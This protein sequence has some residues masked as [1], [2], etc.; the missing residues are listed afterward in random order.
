MVDQYESVVASNFA[1]QEPPDTTGPIAI[2]RDSI[3]AP[4]TIMPNITDLEHNETPAQGDGERAS[5][6]DSSDSMSDG[7]VEI[8][9]HIDEGSRT[10]HHTD[11]FNLSLQTEHPA[12]ES[13]PVHLGA[14]VQDI[15]PFGDSVEN[16]PQTSDLSATQALDLISDFPDGISSAASHDSNEAEESNLGMDVL[17]TP[18]AVSFN[19]DAALPMVLSASTT[20]LQDDEMTIDDEYVSA[21]PHFSN[22]T[23]EA[24]FRYIRDNSSLIV[25]SDLFTFAQDRRLA[26]IPMSTD[27]DTDASLRDLRDTEKFYVSDDE[28]SVGDTTEVE[29]GTR[30]IPETTDIYT[31]DPPLLGDGSYEHGM[32][33]SALALSTDYS[34][35]FDVVYAQHNNENEVDGNLNNQ[36]GLSMHTESMEIY[37]LSHS[38]AATAST[39]TETQGTASLRSSDDRSLQYLG[40]KA[41][42]LSFPELGS[43]FA[44]H[45]S[46]L[47]ETR[48]YEL[49][50]FAS[51]LGPGFIPGVSHSDISVNQ[52]IFSFLSGPRA[53]HAF[54]NT[55]THYRECILDFISRRVPRWKGLLTGS[56]SF[57]LDQTP[58]SQTYPAGESSLSPA[59]SISGI[60]ARSSSAR[61]RRPLLSE[62]QYHDLHELSQY[63]YF[64]I[65]PSLVLQAFKDED[66]LASSLLASPLAPSVG[67]FYVDANGNRYPAFERNLTVDQ[68]IRQWYLR[69]RIPQC[70]LGMM[71]D[72]FIQISS[73]AAHVL[74]WERPAK[75]S[76]PDT[77]RI[78]D[79]QG[80][81]WSTKLNVKRSDARALRDRLYTSYHNLKYIPGYYSSV[82]PEKEGYFSP[83]TMYTKYRAGMAHFQL[84]N[85]M[86]V[87]ASNTIQYAYQ[88]KV[89]SITPFYD[90][91]TCLINLSDPS[92]S[93][94]FFDSVKISTMKAKHGVTMVGG[95]CG[96][97]A[98]RGEISDFTVMEGRVTKDPNGI[99]NHI[100]IIHRRAGPQAVIS[101]ND[102]RI[103]TLD[104]QTNKFVTIH[105]FARAINCTDTSPDGRLRVIIGDAPDV[106][107]IDSET[108]KPV[109]TLVGHSDY[110][111]ACAWSPDML[112]IATS[113]QDKT[114]NIWDARMWRILKSIDSD[115]AGYR[116][117]RFSP[118]G[119]GP[120]TLLMCEPA[121]RI[122]IVNAQTYQTRQVHDFFGE[123]GGADY[124]PDGSRIWVANMDPKFG[125]FMEFD[126][127]EWGQEFGI[128]HT[129]KRRIECRGDVYHPDL[130]NEWVPEYD[131]DDDARCVLGARERKLRFQKL[132]NSTQYEMLDP[133][134]G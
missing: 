73:E 116:S 92:S 113:N 23:Y 40:M 13:S 34:P 128:G 124:S 63:S 78:Y 131:L 99:T 61:S 11:S 89:Y 102:D 22:E 25:H 132:F 56:V 93:R 106:W 117:L 64:F 127:R 81:P 27:D 60:G 80:I 26:N 77:S 107:I 38:F 52:P 85:L 101:S 45:F 29:T 12:S 133:Y 32:T 129:R 16:F 48:V 96:E 103:R 67:E 3:K 43:S 82:L 94:V 111:F 7:G 54:P 55:P 84:R 75:I 9:D 68:F 72:P 36:G 65:R 120:R 51:R 83:K 112:H 8:S 86:S 62:E 90:K 35:Q 126:R 122:S 19:P 47:T 97:Y 1:S 100:D 108:G 50:V 53:F 110:G 24:Y 14:S 66:H 2:S 15:Q 10:Q 118:V 4:D 18:I 71:K 123:I 115:V 104:C 41:V 87:T 42:P 79:I 37:F 31:P 28:F 114:V 88:S 109:Q 69:C 119:G 30:H 46:V 39:I 44:K 91:Q 121:D 49:L 76:R 5:Y 74:D 20:S 17:A 21:E 98:F 95:F 130:P 57:T 125:G 134:L 33:A 70:D 105:K 59:R 58:D 6:I